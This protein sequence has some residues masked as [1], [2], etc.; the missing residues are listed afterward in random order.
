M[1]KKR[2][3]RRSSSMPLE[4]ARL[5]CLSS[6]LWFGGLAPALHFLLLRRIAS[7]G[8]FLLEN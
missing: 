3:N 8:H 1:L 2:A 7:A 6:G 5:A 4:N